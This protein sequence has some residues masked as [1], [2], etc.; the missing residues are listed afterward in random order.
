[1]WGRRVVVPLALALAGLGWAAMHSLA[2]RAVMSGGTGADAAAGTHA[3]LSYLPT[4]LALC[5][6]LALPL[7]AGAA[8]GR[9]A[10]RTSARSLWLF[11][12]VPVLGFAGPALTEPVLLEAS[13]SAPLGAS[14]STLAPILLVGLL[15]QI[16][17]ALGAL[18]LAR[19]AL[20]F[21]EAL[22]RSLARA[23]RPSY[24]HAAGRHAPLAGERAP[25]FGLD[26][27]HPQRAPPA[28]AV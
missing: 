12:A 3:Y 1:M 23:P 22:A 13:S 7:A 18:G 24:R 21:A 15:V 14:A 10:R 28:L 4:S 25:A 17:F 6:A 20:R 16:P 11:G 26:R 8:L 19:G 9:R 2:H 5:F 27:A